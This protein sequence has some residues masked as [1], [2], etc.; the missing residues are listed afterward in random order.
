MNDGDLT[1]EHLGSDDEFEV[2][3]VLDYFFTQAE[4]GDILLVPEDQRLPGDWLPCDGRTVPSWQRPAFAQAMRLSGHEFTLPAP[5]EV[6]PGHAFAIK[7][8]IDPTG[9]GSDTTVDENRPLE[10]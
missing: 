3:Y 6:R 8:G 9:H 10:A 5:M 7:V 4:I 2:E 1:Q